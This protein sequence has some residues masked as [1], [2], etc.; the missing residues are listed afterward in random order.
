MLRDGRLPSAARGET[1]DREVPVIVEPALF[2]RVPSDLQFPKGLVAPEAATFDPQSR[3]AMIVDAVG[4][5]EG[6]LPQIEWYR[7]AFFAAA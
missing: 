7:G 3:D 5:A 2:A 6:L 4:G 1:Y